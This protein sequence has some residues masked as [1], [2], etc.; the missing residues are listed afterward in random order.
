[1]NAL[2]KDTL[3]H[4]IRD[5][6]QTQPDKLAVC[7]MKKTVTYAQYWSNIRKMASLLSEEGIVR[8][9]HVVIRCFQTIDFLTVFTAVQYM[10]AF[11][12]PVEQGISAERILEISDAMDGEVLIS[13][14]P[15]EG[16]RFVSIRELSKKL[17][18][19]KEADY[20]MPKAEDR[21]MLLYTTGTTGD[22]K[23]VVIKHIN[24]VSIC[25]NI[26][27]GTGM[28]KDNVELVP[29]PL[30]HAFGMRRY[31]A[32][33]VNGSTVCLINGVVFIGN[34]WKLMELY[35]VTALGLT[36]AALN[37]I[38]ELSGDTLADYNQQLD[39]VQIGAA[40]LL[41]TDKQKLKALLPS[42]RLYD[43]YGTS[44]CGCICILDFN[45]EDNKPGCVGRLT[46]NAQ[47]RFTDMEGNMIP[48]VD[49]EHPGLLAL[50]GPMVMEGYYRAPEATAEVMENGFVKTRDVA[51]FDKE[52]RCV[53]VG[54]ADDII[55]FGGH[56]I[57]PAEVENCAADY[58][59]I[60]ECAY[61]YRQ[62]PLAGQVPVMLIVKA[63]G[64]EEAAFCRFL[65][66]R[67]ESY[68]IPKAIFE[69]EAL[70][71]TFKGTLLRKEIQKM[72]ESLSD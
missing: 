19:A 70:P 61:T 14:R 16:I 38:F 9:T 43:F 4:Y 32:N 7:E 8:N 26:I 33:M 12:I 65:A 50:G 46:V 62:D 40:P 64:Y 1:M 28:K 59:G 47:V 58:P 35:Q 39:Y 34:V 23:G 44:E 60:A 49:E 21:S 56:K 5:Y 66:D 10:G 48:E 22:S 42:V 18:N 29:M 13:D 67:L 20:E 72:A 63:E 52:G 27:G 37:V 25:E 45:S 3:L 6:A 41:E 30:N 15:M 71:K 24:D 54:R 51:Y 2:R 17:E 68:K 31:E 36:P 53:L 69:T 57:S 11:P 55:N